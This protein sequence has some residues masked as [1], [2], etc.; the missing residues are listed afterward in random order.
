MQQQQQPI[1]YANA[2][3][4]MKNFGQLHVCS[5]DGD[6]I[7][8]L[9]ATCKVT[10]CHATHDNVSEILQP[11]VLSLLNQ[12][13]APNSKLQLQKMA[14]GY[15]L[16]SRENNQLLSVIKD[17]HICNHVD[18]NRDNHSGGEVTTYT[19]V[20][21]PGQSVEPFVIKKHSDDILPP[22]QISGFSTIDHIVAKMA[23]AIPLTQEPRVIFHGPDNFN[24]HGHDVTDADAYFMKKTFTK[25]I[26]STGGQNIYDIPIK[27]SERMSR[28]LT[29]NDPEG[30]VCIAPLAD[31]IMGYRNRKHNAGKTLIF[32]CTSDDFFSKEPKPP[33][34]SK[35][36][37][38][39][40]NYL[41]NK[42]KAR[43]ILVKT[44]PTDP[45]YPP[46]EEQECVPMMGAKVTSSS[47]RAPPIVP[48]MTVQECLNVMD[49]IF[50]KI[51]MDHIQCSD[52]PQ[53]CM[54]AEANK[55]KTMM[56]G[57]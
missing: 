41:N 55:L 28:L 6:H 36:R 25:L 52:F 3:H 4:C 13:A 5:F 43:R 1:K 14:D 31:G 57:G 10:P 2:V 51:N 27:M 47:Y 48:Q 33:A 22:N 32:I 39:K 8:G 42:C 50:R 26:N 29:L 38:Y 7:T 17:P 37:I 24:L 16:V 54:K 49:F 18:T 46:D 53:Y 21:P 20:S 12:A 19:V 35:V 15:V 11:H 9:R 23:S 30:N 34:E 45:D 40:L 56:M 44:L